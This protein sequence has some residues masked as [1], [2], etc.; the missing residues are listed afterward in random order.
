M[1]ERMGRAEPTAYVEFSESYVYDDARG[2]SVAY[3]NVEDATRWQERCG[4]VTVGEHEEGGYW[5]AVYSSLR[6]EIVCDGTA[7]D[8]FSAVHIGLFVLS[9]EPMGVN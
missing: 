9:P 5:Y 4:S 8:P 1:G 7:P 2:L 6:A 3:F